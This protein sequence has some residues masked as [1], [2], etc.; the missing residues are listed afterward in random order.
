M[1][2]VFT[3]KALLPA[4]PTVE[5]AA[6][7]FPARAKLDV[8][9]YVLWQP[10]CHGAQT[11]KT[12][13]WSPSR[14]LFPACSLLPAVPMWSEMRFHSLPGLNDGS[15]DK[16]FKSI[17]L[18]RCVSRA[19]LCFANWQLHF[20]WFLNASEHSMRFYLS[21]FAESLFSACFR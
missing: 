3:E 14:T 18:G 12:A 15:C 7:I 1:L 16:S 8:L 9:S 5:A 10:K 21:Q 20:A 2:R 17:R 6:S 19:E 4:P 13:G 11:S